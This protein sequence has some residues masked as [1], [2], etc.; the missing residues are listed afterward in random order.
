MPD[1]LSTPAQA[2]WIEELGR[3]IGGGASELDSSLF[4]RYCA[5]EALLREA[6]AN[7]HTPPAAFLAE[8]RR[9][10]ELLGLAGPK[11]RPGARPRE[12]NPFERNGKRPSGRETEG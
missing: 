12:K 7:G 11:S 1:Y 9:V 3:V 4:A 2:I 8:Q 5:T 10:A 6:F